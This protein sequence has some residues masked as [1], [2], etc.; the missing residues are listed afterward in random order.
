MIENITTKS[1]TITK[2]ND[3]SLKKIVGCFFIA[4]K[5]Y[6]GLQVMEV[7]ITSAE[8][9]EAFKVADKPARRTIFE[10][11]INALYPEWVKLYAVD[12]IEVYD[13]EDEIRKVIGNPII[14]K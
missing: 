10:T 13:G 12:H 3:R 2:A 6:N 1:I 4:S 8:E 9:L 7:E 11:K 14:S 5:A